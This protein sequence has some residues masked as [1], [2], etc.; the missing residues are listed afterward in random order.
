MNKGISVY[1]AT[2]RMPAT[3]LRWICER[4]GVHFYRNTPGMTAV[5]GDYLFVHTGEEAGEHEFQWHR[6]CESIERLATYSAR[7]LAKQ[8]SVWRDTLEARTTAIY[9]CR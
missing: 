5:V 8:T 6:A 9:R 2:P 3:L 4:S 1:S 7:P